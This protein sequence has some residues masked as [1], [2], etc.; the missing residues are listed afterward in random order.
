MLLSLLR[1]LLGFATA[2]LAAGLVQVAFV[3]TPLEIAT[4]EPAAIPDRLS[5]AGLLALFAA[6]HSAVFSAPFAL[7]AAAFAEWQGIRS[8]IYYALAGIAIALAGVLT[9]HASETGAT[10]IVN[11]YALR[12]FLAA[13]FVAG[14]AYWVVAG[15]SAGPRRSQHKRAAGRN[16]MGGAA[17]APDGR[18]SGARN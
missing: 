12:A 1:I 2:C 7:L 11:D 9:Q 17:T 4:L 16:W 15:R 18:R 3:I 8:W 10:T 6:T 5:G 13:G 14:L